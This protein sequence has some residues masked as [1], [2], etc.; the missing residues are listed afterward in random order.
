MASSSPGLE[1]PGKEVPPAE[2]T[3]P[4]LHHPPD[5]NLSPTLQSEPPH[6]QPVAVALNITHVCQEELGSAIF[7]APIP[8][9]LWRGLP[10]ELRYGATGLG[11]SLHLNAGAFWSGLQR[12]PTL[13]L[14][15]KAQRCFAR[16]EP[17]A[18]AK[19]N[20]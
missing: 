1:T 20:V 14:K 7:V 2:V 5:E 10:G 15:T 3:V 16:L 6:P 11:V 18:E 17:T 9:R 19:A 12:W 8:V 4:V 13:L